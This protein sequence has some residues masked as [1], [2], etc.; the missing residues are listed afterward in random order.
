MKLHLQPT[1]ATT[2]FDKEAFISMARKYG[3][4]FK[5]IQNQIKD[6]MINAFSP[7]KLKLFFF[8]VYLHFYQT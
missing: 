7:I 6:P 5:D 8:K 3:T 1:I 4:I 2:T